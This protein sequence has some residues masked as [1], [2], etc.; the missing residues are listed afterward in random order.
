MTR[1]LLALTP[2]NS[3]FT[4]EGE[5]TKKEGVRRILGYRMS[6]YGFALAFVKRGPAEGYKLVT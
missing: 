2:S 6:W 3:L 1:P 5:R 4:K